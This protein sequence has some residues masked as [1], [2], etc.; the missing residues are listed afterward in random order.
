MFIKLGKIP[1]TRNNTQNRVV[2]LFVA[3]WTPLGPVGAFYGPVGPNVLLPWAETK[4]IHPI[5]DISGVNKSAT[6]PHVCLPAPM[7]TQVVFES[8]QILN[9]RFKLVI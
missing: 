6:L 2:M 4:A 3:F 7:Y 1:K 5:L 9:K 8:F